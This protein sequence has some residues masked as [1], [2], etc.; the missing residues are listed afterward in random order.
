[1][2]EWLDAEAH[3]DR[4]LEMYDRGRWAEAEAEL[5]KALSLNPDQAEWHFN[6]GLTLEAAGRDTEALAA[7]ER[8]VELLPDNVE[9]LVAAGIVAN[10]LGKHRRAIKC[11]GHA[12]RIDPRCEA[13]YGHK[14]ES[15]VRLERHDETETTFYMAQQALDAPSA[16]CLA[17][18]AESL[19]QRGN[20][21]R[22]EWCLKEAMRLDPHMP[23]VRARLGAVYGATG[24]H[25][26]ALQMYVRDLRD[27]PGNVDTLL[28]YGELLVELRRLPE[29]AEK[30]RR[31][32]ELEPANTDA[33]YRLGQIA[34]ASRRYD[35]AQ[36]EFELVQKLD[37]QFPRIRVAIA[38]VVLR[39]GQTGKARH[40]LREA[41]DQFEA[42]GGSG[43][44][45]EL[46]QLGSLLLQAGLPGE[47]AQLFAR[48]MERCGESAALMRK[49]AL[50]SFL[51]GD[52]AG[53]IAASRRVLRLDPRCVTAMHNL[54]LAAL[55]EDRLRVAAGWIRRGLRIDR[56]DEGLRRLRIRLWL[57][58]LGRATARPWAIGRRRRRDK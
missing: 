48:V 53:G 7:H 19:H 9:P 31:V 16:H 3:A 24:R 35:R 56:H 8:A 52:R 18:M 6:L 1:M 13:A 41:L 58:W 22:A 36:L 43:Q 20:Y 40:H 28:D 45:G 10:R 5:R 30:F 4:A 12:L 29:A 26:R 51:A 15:Y 55:E 39:Q 23:R 21:R 2:G 34:L 42:G 27:D 46:S 25:Q 37:S 11:L 54:A 49:L 32:L 17:V 33:H 14:M 44:T 38:D 47:A 50:A 57:T